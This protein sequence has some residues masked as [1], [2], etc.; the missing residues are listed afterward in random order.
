MWPH[1]QRLRVWGFA[2][3]RFFSYFL[4]LRVLQFWSNIYACWRSRFR[5]PRCTCDYSSWLLVLWGPIHSAGKKGELYVAAL[6]A[7]A[8]LGVWRGSLV[9]RFFF[10]YLFCGFGLIYTRVGGYGFEVRCEHA[11]IFLGFW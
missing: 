10:R 9:F 6:A 7:G 5:K 2:A 4:S 11:T 3:G 8:S 1:W